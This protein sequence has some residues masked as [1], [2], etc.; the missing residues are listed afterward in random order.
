[1]RLTKYE[2]NDESMFPYKLKDEELS[3]ELD[4]VHKLGE[5]EDILE[6]HNI[7][8]LSDLDNRLAALEIIKENL[9]VS[10]DESE[11]NKPCLI[12]GI[13]SDKDNLIV[14]YETFD[15]EKIDLLKEALK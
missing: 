13:K 4:S 5:A 6:K 9:V 11:N 14:F 8:S 10:Y 3:T 15:K 7:S 1:M 2:P 12:I